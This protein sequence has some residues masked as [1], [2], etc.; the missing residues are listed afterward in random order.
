MCPRYGRPEERSLTSVYIT[1]SRNLCFAIVYGKFI[2]VTLGL[3]PGWVHPVDLFWQP[4]GRFR[5]SVG[6]R[7]CCK[8]LILLDLVCALTEVEIFDR[9]H[10]SL[11]HKL[12]RINSGL[13]YG[14]SRF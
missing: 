10:L 11:D 4:R 14:L 1:V 12:L 2:I 3:D 9:V 7:A 5:P 6:E 8:L 13:S